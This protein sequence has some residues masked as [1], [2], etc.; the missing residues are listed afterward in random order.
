M[1]SV[2]EGDVSLVHV[3]ETQ[4]EEAIIE[5]SRLE[6]PLHFKTT[7]TGIMPSQ[8]V[9]DYPKVPPDWYRNKDEQTH[10][11]EADWRYMDVKLKNDKVQQM[12]IGI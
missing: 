8:D 3:D 11:L 9:R 10:V 12:K 5:A 7:S 6:E 4:D 1:D 2:D